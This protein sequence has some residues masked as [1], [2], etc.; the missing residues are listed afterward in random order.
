M[1]GQWGEQPIAERRLM[2]APLFLSNEDL[3]QLLTPQVATE[4]MEETY[5]AMATGDGVTRTRTQTFAPTGQGDVLMEFR[6]MDGAVPATGTLGIRVLPDL[7]SVPMIGGKRRRLQHPRPNGR[8]LAFNLIFSLQTGELIGIVQD[9][10][11]QR[12][13]MCGAHAAAAKV[14]AK[15]NAATIGMFGSGWLGGGIIEGLCA[16]RPIKKIKVYSTNVQHREKFAE[17]FTG[18]L[19][20][21]V[22]AVARP[23]EAHRDVD[24]VV[25][26][27][28]T[29]DPIFKGEW[30]APGVHLSS[31]LAWEVE[32]DCFTRSD[33]TV[34]SMREGRANEGI[35]YFP[36]NLKERDPHKGV[37]DRR[38]DWERY[39]ELGEVLI[40]QAAGRTNDQE[41]TF[42]CNNIG[43]GAQF[44]ALGG[45]AVELARARG[46]GKEFPIDEWYETIR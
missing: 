1:A 39:P 16:V 36:R 31:V 19:D 40:G 30:L 2:R 20:I 8:F 15:Q 44:G 38:I 42:F 27:T 24:I 32:D 10:Y 22:E 43:F 13:R 12:M 11:L 23:E 41:V 6:T 9:A 14:L 37:F 45:K 17:E 18:R 46:I 25:T 4:V 21:Q 26:A 35:N 28:N 29:V 5:R 34:L 3:E 7:V 33:V